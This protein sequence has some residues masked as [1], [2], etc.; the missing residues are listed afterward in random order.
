LFSLDFLPR[1]THNVYMKV[2]GKLRLQS[3]WQEHPRA[4]KPLEKWTDV[5]EKADWRNWSQLKS[6]FNKAD[7]VPGKEKFIV[8]DIG[9]NKYRLITIVNF[10][11]Q[12][13]V[14]KVVL[15]HSEYDKENWKR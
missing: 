10:A 11:G 5:V 7:L 15:T 8:F 14:V 13:V 9:G 6:T 12:I 4:K 1:C 3:F 2:I